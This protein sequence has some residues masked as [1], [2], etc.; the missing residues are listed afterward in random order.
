MA[1]MPRVGVYFLLIGEIKFESSNP[2]VSFDYA[3]VRAACFNEIDILTFLL[4]INT[5]PDAIDVMDDWSALMYA[6]NGGHYEAVKILL[7][8]KANPNVKGKEGYTAVCL[9]VQMRH[10]A[11]ARMLLQANSDPD[12]QNR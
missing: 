11:I 5:N 10:D 1:F 9:A 8:A 12:V 7:R 2:S 6:S 3:L 4:D